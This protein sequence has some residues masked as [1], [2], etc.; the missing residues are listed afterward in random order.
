MY[1]EAI[2]HDPAI[3]FV[4]TGSQLAGRPSIGAWVSYGLGSENHDLPAYVVLT[5]FGTGRPRR[6]AALRPP[7]GSGFLPSQ[8]PGR[9]VP[10][11]GRR[12]CSISPTRPASTARR[13]GRH[14]R[15][16]GE[17]NRHGIR[18]RG[19]S[20]DPDPHR[21]VRDGLPHADE[22]A[23][24]ARLSR[25]AAARPRAV[26]PRGR[27]PGTYAANCLLA[28]RLAERGRAFHPALPHGLGPPRD[29]PAAIRGQCRDT[30]QATAAPDHRPQAARPAR[31]TR[32]SSGAAS[33]A[34]RSIRRA[35]DGRPTTAATTI[36]A[37][38]R[39]GWP[40]AGVKPGITFGETDD[41]CY[42]ISATPSTSMTCTPRSC[43][44]WAS[45][46]RG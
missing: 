26:R 18:R 6:P 32:W 44:C 23:R 29:L 27:E 10:Q 31:T 13:A 34:A 4:Q 15:R 11:R 22:R 1:T 12:R 8:A 30:D 35:A 38:S 9:Q 14:A 5:S 37:A 42:N 33:S 40:A 21:P 17:L 28:R 19:R 2:N 39:S 16:P 20:R 25:R 7:V 46:T 3:T 36:R 24:A 45:T 41:Y 43:T